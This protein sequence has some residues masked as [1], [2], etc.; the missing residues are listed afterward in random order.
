MTSFLLLQTNTRMMST[1]QHLARSLVVILAVALA[2]FCASAVVVGQLRC[3]YLEDP[4]GIDV[5]QPRLS[6]LL[7][8]DHRTER[9]QAQSGYQVLVANSA[10][11][12]KAG[13]GD[14]WDSGKVASDKS[15]QV[16]YAGK[17][18]ISGQECFWKVRVWDEQGKAS[19]WSE[20][21][22]WTMGLL[23][24]TDW[25]AKWIGRDEPAENEAA[26]KP[27]GQAQW[28][29][30]PE[31][32]P[33]KA[34]PVGTRYFRR[35]LAIPADRVVKRAS[36][37]FTADNS[38]EF[39]ING[40]K[41][42]G[43][44]DF[45]A[46]SQFDVTKE[47]R[48][49]ENVLSVSVHNDGSDPNPAGLVGLLRIEFS[50]GGPLVV[51]TDSSWK[52]SRSEL[53][54]W[55]DAG[56]DE[57]G[58]VAAKQLGSAGMAPWGEISGP[59]DR[60]LPA[61]MLRREFAVEK[62]VRRAVAYVS[63]LGLSEFYLNGRKIGDDVLSPGL[64][65]YTKRVFYITF[66][67]TK[68]LKKGANAVGILLGNGRFYAPRSKAPT[69]TT[70][71]GFPKL[72]FQM[73]IEYQ[74]GTSAEVVSDKTWKLTTDGPIRTNNEYDGEDYDARKEMPG[75]D[76]A[77]F[78]DKNWQPAQAVAAPGGE[79]AAQMINPIRVVETL[80]PLSVTEPK[81]GVWIY[82]L[83]Q[84]MVGWC[85]LK[86]SGPRGTEVKL[87]HAETLKP[88]GTLYLDNI[89]GAKVTDTYTLKGGGTE[90]YELRFTY[91]GFRF[92]ELTGHPGK[93]ALSAIEGRV[94]HDDVATSGEFTCSNPLLNQIYRNIVWGVS[95]NY[96]SIATDC[97]QRDER[98]G[99]LGDRSA[100]SKGE[101]YM[102][103]TA[104]FHTKWLQDMADAQKASGSVPD[105]CPAYWPIYSDNVTWPSTTVLLP[106]SMRE[107]YADEGIIAAH[108]A[109]AK[110]WV[111]YMS[112]FVT[113]GI[114]SRDTYGDWC[115]PPEDPKLIHSNDP[116]RKTDKALLATAY[117]YHD[118]RVMARYATL[119]GKTDDARRFETLAATMK[120]AFNRKFFRASEGQYDNGSQTSCVLPLAFGLVPEHER[121]RLFDALVR[122]ITVE[123]R[124]HIGTGL[125]GAQWL[126]RVLT[127]GGRADVAYAIASQKTYPSWGYMVERGATTI[128][129]LWNGDTADPAMN[130]G[131]HVMLVG[132]LGI[133]LYENLAGIKPDPERPGF[134]HIV[135]RPEPVGDLQ[136][137]K[138]TRR[139][140]YGLIVSDWQRKDGVFRWRITV[141]VNSTATV[142][143][144]AK[145][146]DDVTESGR[147]GVQSAG[148]RLLRF[149]PGRA[150][151]EVKSGDYN[152]Q[153][154]L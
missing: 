22:R 111:D 65:D 148:A 115:V 42:G 149:E 32:Q 26:N 51:A 133:W 144:P 12:L 113:N 99:W 104:A 138:A 147:P 68:Q 66:D 131:N 85:R 128:W 53:A 72:L 76:R 125:I 127:D 50:Q 8:A 75:W 40:Q 123:T 116:K 14:L 137:V 145:S 152:F 87:R 70:G 91:H 28:I 97:P 98:Q 5:M 146:A 20:P 55:K 38:G 35:V 88:D 18:L 46:A 13:G 83:G 39:F 122:K 124:G 153:S 48:A 60:R 4:L 69:G 21:A 9:G 151:F 129:E 43:A 49:G 105:V 36:L 82:D 52:A 140:P 2:P 61:R 103:D 74:D 29:W 108:Y 31:G 44:S 81:P 92:V 58:W 134:K 93:P 107:M 54:G 86:V 119:L 126:M 16:R 90:V 11:E 27:L 33:E 10:R 1:H 56:L 24:P 17:P 110:K 23:R 57:A 63:G 150:V 96:R 89:R 59:E 109:S 143:V 62:K 84:N 154:S 3:E 71:Y 130:S 132:D 142:Y 102:F 30:F 15:I 117:F 67:V 94:V 41:V 47:L 64:T 7:S 77:G 25:H 106:E 45:H 136:F 34:A 114:I 78:D 73:H 101:M 37:S 120:E 95:G 135:M 100:E 80:K 19:A 121:G 6:W 139:A 141:P 118:A 112:G 79:L